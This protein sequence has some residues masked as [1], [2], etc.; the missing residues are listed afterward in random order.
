MERSLNPKV[1][2]EAIQAFN[3]VKDV[4]GE[5]LVAVYL[6]GSATMGGLRPQSDVDLLVVVNQPLSEAK[7]SELVSRLMTVSGAIGNANFVRPIELTVLYLADVVP[8]TYPPKSELVYGEWLREE[9]ERYRVPKPEPDPDL[10]IVMT[11]ARQ[12][13]IV[14]FGPEAQQLLD[15]IPGEHLERALEDSL[16]RLLDGL[17]GDERNVLL[18]L[19]RMWRTAAT[20]DLVPKDVAASWAIARLPEAYRPLLELA[21]DAYLGDVADSWEGKRPA[22]RALAGSM[23]RAIAVR[24][25]ERNASNP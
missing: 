1:P 18:T 5:T 21:R 16:T 2:E 7:R 8:W 24:L 12:S 25:A 9:F 3:L 19:A 11:Q 17:E 15:P 13:S 6:F 10:A 14:L 20:G 22:V 4:L 23:S